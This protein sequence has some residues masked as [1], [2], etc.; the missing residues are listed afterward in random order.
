MTRLDSPYTLREV[1]PS[2]TGLRI[3]IARIDAVCFPKRRPWHPEPRD[4]VWLVSDGDQRAV[5]Y[6]VLSQFHDL[7]GVGYLSRAAVMPKHRGNGLQAWLIDAR[8]RKARERGYNVL[9]SNCNVEN[10]SS[11]NNLIEA[12]FE[13]FRPVEL[14]DG[15]AGLYFRKVLV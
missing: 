1:E 2:D 7:S 14:W 3:E 9:L 4:I 10:A 15:A 12:G 5:A 11:A 8:E 6:A 13:M